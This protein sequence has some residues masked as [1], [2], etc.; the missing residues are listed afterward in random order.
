MLAKVRLRAAEQRLGNLRAAAADAEALPFPTASFD[1]VTCRF[2]LMFV[3][4]V[5]AALAEVRRVLK[6]GG[7]AGFLVWGPLENNALFQVIRDALAAVL[8]TRFDT[9]DTAQ[10]RFGAPDSVAA[11]MRQAGFSGIVEEDRSPVRNAPAD[12]AFWQANKTGRAACRERV[13]QYG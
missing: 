8:D 4:D 5:P 9:A 7:R 13:W 2:G 12:G 10:F 6:P 11:P 3:S 1:R